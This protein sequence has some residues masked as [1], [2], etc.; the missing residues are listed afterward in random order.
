MICK[1]EQM[2][3]SGTCPG[4][5][6]KCPKR[7]GSGDP[8]TFGTCPFRACPIVP[9]RHD[10][11]LS[12][13]IDGSG[14]QLEAEFSGE[15]APDSI[16]ERELRDFCASDGADKPGHLVVSGAPN[17]DSRVKAYRRALDSLVGQGILSGFEHPEN[18]ERH[19]KPSKTRAT[20][21]THH[22]P[23]HTRTSPD[24]TEM[25][26]P[27]SGGDS[28]DRHGQPPI[29]VSGCPASSSTRTEGKQR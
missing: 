9:S 12:C 26:D 5:I 2:G 1:V 18:G 16:A 28:P 3:H 8:G 23:G 24:K 14:A 20:D 21:S 11:L 25:S 29:G 6:Q 22:Q 27:C 4:Q 17:R 15:A 10:E 13:R 7:K 19:I